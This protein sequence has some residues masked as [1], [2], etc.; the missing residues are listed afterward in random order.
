M[1]TGLVLEGGAMR[2]MFTAGAIDVMME[3]GIEYDGLIGVSAGATFGCNYKSHQIGRSIR[4]NKRFCR[5]P[6]YCSLRSLIKTGD[7]Y[8]AEFCYRELP[9]KL[10]IFDVDTFSKSPMAFYCVCTDADTGNPVYHQCKTGD[11][12]DLDWMRASASMPVASRTVEIDGL[13]LLDGG[14]S[15]SIPLKYFESIGYEKNVVV[16]TQPG[17]YLKEKQKHLPFLRLLLK[18]YPAVY[19]RLE[20]RH[21]A[22]NSELRYIRKRE[23]EGAVFVIRPEGPLG[24]GSVEHNPDELQRVYDE[25]RRVMQAELGELRNFLEK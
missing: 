7:L 4:Y 2:G 20:R 16:L 10:D 13:H 24:V 8:G 21:I 14:I 17:G 22:Y 3:N 6:K 18:N 23:K 15:D 5:E 25:G 19:R 12:R 1:K 9:D 11:H